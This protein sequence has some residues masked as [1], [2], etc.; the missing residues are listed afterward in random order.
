[1]KQF[2]NIEEVNNF[3]KT[4]KINGG[5]ITPL[6]NELIYL[7]ASTGDDSALQTIFYLGLLFGRNG[8][9]VFENEL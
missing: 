7:V 5:C 4:L 8:Y 2:N 6:V 1:M 9:A 3:L